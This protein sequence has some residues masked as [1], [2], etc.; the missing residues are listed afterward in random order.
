MFCAPVS[1]RAKI[2]EH[3]GTYQEPF[4]ILQ[5]QGDGVGLRAEVARKSVI[6]AVL[7][8]NFQQTFH[9]LKKS[10]KFWYHMKVFCVY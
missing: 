10:T 4:R 6:S 8:F 5:R 3:P 7:K 9:S 1:N 2:S